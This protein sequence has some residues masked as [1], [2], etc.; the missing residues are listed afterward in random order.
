MKNALK[1]IKEKR[2]G[3]K[4]AAKTF[5]VPSTTLRRRFKNE[6]GSEKGYLGGCKLTFT[7]QLEAD[8]VTHIMELD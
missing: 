6:K 4:L 5:D 1:A 3:W 2:M 7:S 8:L